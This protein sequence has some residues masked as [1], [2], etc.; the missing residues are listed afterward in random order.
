[1]AHSDV[2]GVGIIVSEK[3]EVFITGHFEYDRGTLLFEYERDLTAGMNPHVPDNYFEDDDPHKDP[4]V[5]WRSHASL[6]Y[7]NWL[8]YYVYQETYYDIENIGRD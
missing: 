5:R 1:M 8:N 7:T 2:A 3:R 6:F 4:I